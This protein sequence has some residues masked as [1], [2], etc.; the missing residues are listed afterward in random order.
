MTS[1]QGLMPGQGAS[2]AQA[3]AALKRHKDVMEAAERIFEGF[4]DDV[5]DENCD[6]RGPLDVSAHEQQAVRMVVCTSESLSRRPHLI[7]DQDT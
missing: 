7:L 2:A 5:C 6:V 4:F 1:R 3:R